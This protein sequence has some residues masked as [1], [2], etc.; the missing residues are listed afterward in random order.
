MRSVMDWIFYGPSSSPLP[1]HLL[2]HPCYHS[3]SIPLSPSL[4]LS[5]YHLQFN[6]HL[7]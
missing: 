3:Q 7:G 5:E 1:F 2:F 6:A 4:R